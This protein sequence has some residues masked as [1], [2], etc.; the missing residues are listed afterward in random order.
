MNSVGSILKDFEW[1]YTGTIRTTRG[2]GFQ[3]KG[4]SRTLFLSP[5]VEEIPVNLF[6]VK[7]SQSTDPAK[8]GKLVFKYLSYRLDPNGKY[9]DLAPTNITLETPLEE[10]RNAVVSKFTNIEG[11]QVSIGVGLHGKFTNITTA[12]GVFAIYDEDKFKNPD[13][14]ISGNAPYYI[15]SDAIINVKL[16]GAVSQNNEY[17]QT[18]L[19]TTSSSD[20]I[21]QKS[22]A[23]KVW[24]EDSADGAMTGQA[25][26]PASTG[27]A[28]W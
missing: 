7:V 1:N 25:D 27:Q 22:S 9:V 3:G 2:T 20:E 28:V 24:G 19:S 15:K 5:K 11:A 16:K 4:I 13:P 6:A 23:G 26:A 12:D 18:T 17:L 10:V 21:F 8:A 14:N